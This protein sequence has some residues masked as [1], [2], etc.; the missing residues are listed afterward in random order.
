MLI[1]LTAAF[2]PGHYSNNSV[3]GLTNGNGYWTCHEADRDDKRK[4]CEC[5]KDKKKECYYIAKASAGHFYLDYRY[6]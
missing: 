4:R 2:E 6:K 3:T 1:T 5:V